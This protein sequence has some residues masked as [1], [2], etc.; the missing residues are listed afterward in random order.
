MK[1]KQLPRS[2][3]KAA[4]EAAKRPEAQVNPSLPHRSAVA[5]QAALEVLG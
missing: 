3:R 2:T 5:Y 4:Q 1:D